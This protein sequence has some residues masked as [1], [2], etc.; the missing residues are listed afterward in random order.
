MKYD[1][2]KSDSENRRTWEEHWFN[3]PSTDYKQLHEHEK[4]WLRNLNQMLRQFEEKFY[5]VL[6]AKKRELQARV[7]EPSDWMQEF[8][9]G[10]MLTIYLREDDP[11]FE[12]DDDNILIQLNEWFVREDAVERGWGFGATEIDHAMT[13]VFPMEKHCYLY[14]QL[15]DHYFLDWRD[16]L[17]IGSLYL[18]IQ[19]EEQSGV[20]PVDKVAEQSP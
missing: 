3:A 8:N 13:D 19:I 14:H 9:L 10:F 17:R 11:E 12:D 1:S 15:Y 4:V 20:L 5:P 18:D 7:L 6:V 2:K 16:L